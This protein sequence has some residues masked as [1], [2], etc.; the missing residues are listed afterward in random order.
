MQ[1]RKIRQ[2][3]FAG[4]HP[5]LHRKSAV[6]GLTE[7][8]YTDGQLTWSHRKACTGATAGTGLN[9]PMGFDIFQQKYF[10]A[11]IKGIYHG[12]A[13]SHALTSK[14]ELLVHGS[15]LSLATDLGENG[16]TISDV[17]KRSKMRTR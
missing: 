6:G 10:K 13:T 12:I 5:Q 3:I 2:N 17:L 1:A 8:D 14:S 16:Q 11:T 4:C 7:N 9:C 15:Y